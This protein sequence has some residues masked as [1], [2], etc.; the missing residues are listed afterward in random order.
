MC[1]KDLIENYPGLKAL[2]E[3]VYAIDAI[4][5]WMEKRPVTEVWANRGHN[6]QFVGMSKCA[7]FMYTL[8]LSSSL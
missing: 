3:S 4:K 8:Y 1:K 2:V 5:A 6:F 7:I